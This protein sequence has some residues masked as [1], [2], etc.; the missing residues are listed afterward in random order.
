MTSSI[1]NGINLPGLPILM[2][3][4]ELDRARRVNAPQIEVDLA[5]Y[6]SRTMTLKATQLVKVFDPEHP[7]LVSLPGD[8]DHDGGDRVA[9]RTL[10]VSRITEPVAQGRGVYAQRGTGEA[11]DLTPWV[12]WETGSTRVSLGEVTKAK[13]GIFN[14]FRELQDLR[15]NRE[16]PSS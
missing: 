14:L 3:D 11:V 9:P 10:M 7:D 13:H 2:A 15:M 4:A 5:R 6:E 12:E 1:Q 16:L 8:D